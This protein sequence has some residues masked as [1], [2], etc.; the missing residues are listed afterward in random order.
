MT[1]RKLPG[2][3]KWRVLSEKNHKNMGTYSSRPA[4]VK[5]LQQVEFFKHRSRW[6]K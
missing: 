2:V 3:N 6:R 1:I 4:A 5:R